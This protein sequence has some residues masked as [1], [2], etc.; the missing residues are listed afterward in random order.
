VEKK[1]P[2]KLAPKKSTVREKKVESKPSQSKP[3]TIQDPATPSGLE[4]IEINPI[5][6]EL[7]PITIESS[8]DNSGQ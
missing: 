6:L 4:T 8:P 5:Q 1:A 2:P 7:K 3:A